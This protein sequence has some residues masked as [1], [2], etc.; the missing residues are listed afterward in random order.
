MNAF[1]RATIQR[2]SALTVFLFILLMGSSAR[3]QSIS[4]NS[5][6]SS[7]CA[8][9]DIS[10]T[11]RATSGS[12]IYFLGSTFT[13]YI[14]SPG[15]VAP[16]TAFDSSSES[17]WHFWSGSSSN[18]TRSVTLPSS[19][20]PGQYRIAIGSTSPTYNASNGENA[21]ELFQVTN[22]RAGTISGPSVVCNGQSATL[23]LNNYSGNVQWQS[24]TTPNTSNSW[25]NISG[26][27]GGTYTINSVTQTR[28]YRCVVSAITPCTSSNL[29]TDVFKV[30]VAAAP[31]GGT[32]SGSGTVCAGSNRTLSISGQNGSVQWQSSTDNQNWSN[33]AG[34]TGTS[35]TATNLTQTT[36]FR[37]LVSNAA[38][39]MNSS[40]ATVT[41]LSQP[42]AGTIS[43]ATSVCAGVNSTT[44]TANG[45]NGSIQWQTALPN[46]SFQDMNGQTGQTL[47]VTNLSDSKTYRL[48][49]TNGSCGTVYSDP[50]TVT[51]NQPSMAGTV[52]GGGEVCPGSVTIL[53][54]INSRGII[55]WQSSFDGVTFTDIAGQNA[56]TLT[57]S[58]ISQIT[59]FRAIVTNGNCPSATTNTVTI[60]PG[61]T[62]TWNGTQWSNGEPTS[63]RPAI[64][65]GNYN[66]NKDLTA[67]T[68]T[69]TNNATVVIPSGRDV[70]LTGAI[71]VT[72]GTFT[73]EN[74][75][76]LIQSS[77]VA[78]TGNISVKRTTA[79]LKRLDYVIWSAPITGQSLRSFSP[80]TSMSPSS[81][82]YQYTTS[83]N[84]YNMITNP[85]E[86][87][88]ETA[89][90]YLIRLPN[91][92]PTTPTKWTGT[93]TG[94]PNNGT[95]T[96]MMVNE[97]PGKRYNL[98]GNPYPSPISL[99]AFMA[100]NANNITGAVYFWRKT[101]GAA[102]PSYCAFVNGTFVSN[103]DAT[104]NS[105]MGNGHPLGPNKTI[106]V[107]Q[108]FFVEAKND[109][110]AVVF[111]NQMRVGDNHGH[112]L[113]TAEVEKHR[114]WL[115]VTN[116]NGAFAQ[117]ALVYTEEASSTEEDAFDAK[118]FNDGVVSIA[119]LQN[120]GKFIVNGRA[121]FNKFDIVPLSFTADAA[122]NYTI[123]IDQVDGL[124]SNYSTIFLK[125][126]LTGA[127]FNLK[128]SAY[129]FASEVG[130][131]NE[132]FEIRYI[133]AFAKEAADTP[134]SIVAYAK[135][136]TIFANSG[137]H[138]M[139]AYEV[140]D[141][142]G[143]LITSG[144]AAANEIAVPVHA[145]EQILI[146]RV[147]METGETVSTK[148]RI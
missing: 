95:K 84:F 32:V 59:Y 132:R 41:V 48:K 97:G 67:C 70:N 54:L 19:L 126:K 128:K 129:T 60:A 76:N 85:S 12:G 140:Y 79:S 146:V 36:Y 10:L 120:G 110:T 127:M 125:D 104:V 40:T 87:L 112:L 99:D 22:H 94:V 44:L 38:C 102:N 131:F 30:S 35:Y 135:N 96:F 6:P 9:N 93:F 136:A 62:T 16:Y 75:A 133:K 106:G 27:T 109:A 80:L 33:V 148:V 116:S 139:K 20:E 107:G 72:S 5:V 83:T 4:V 88:F 46:G 68:L 143:R 23:A 37:C 49:V 50:V 3:S 57:T 118:Y 119:A 1:T 13:Y 111:N 53:T 77:D 121:S 17:L 86:T 63:A 142:Q 31:V 123:A 69:I 2:F 138:T 124:F 34:Q 51:V 147:Q 115:N 39:S 71:N 64:I 47:V 26:A 108:G 141:L 73:L 89:K 42:V 90:G 91:N 122:G 24:T 82:Y 7:A 130:E 55:Q 29:R 61:D 28:Y 137:M 18:L 103:G 81:R 117:M 65:A 56:T 58:T 11:L 98:V 74:N 8:G 100:A 105:M 145:A 78:N 144:H 92:H 134:A 43:G 15:G 45:Y 52:T 113:R 21:S 101:N 66:E 25:Q 14:S 114:I